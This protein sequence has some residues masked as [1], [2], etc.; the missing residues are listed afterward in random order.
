M[1]SFNSLTLTYIYIQTDV[2]LLIQMPNIYLHIVKKL[3]KSR[4]QLK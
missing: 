4:Q 3:L 2:T 1:S